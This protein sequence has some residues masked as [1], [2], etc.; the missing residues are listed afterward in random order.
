MV[1]VTRVPVLRLEFTDHGTAVIGGDNVKDREDMWR[2]FAVYGYA[3]FGQMVGGV[4]PADL[5]PG[6]SLAEALGKW[7][8]RH[9]FV[10]AAALPMGEDHGWATDDFLAAA[11]TI[12]R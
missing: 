10:A 7:I 2:A 3:E 12:L 5:R 4:A 6:D 11:M 1:T 8:A 9:G